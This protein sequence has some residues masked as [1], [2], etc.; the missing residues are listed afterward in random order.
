V[1]QDGHIPPP[2]GVVT[3][4]VARGAQSQLPYLTEIKKLKNAVIYE[5]SIYLLQ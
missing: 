1:R 4:L 3:F 5:I 2:S